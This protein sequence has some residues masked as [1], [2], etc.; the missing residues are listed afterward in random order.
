MEILL[1]YNEILCEVI[2]TYFVLGME[3]QRK[4]VQKSTIFRVF[5]RVSL[6]LNEFKKLNNSPL[7]RQL[8]N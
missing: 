6:Y 3:L 4:L 1:Y 5:I 8:L 7:L 2:V